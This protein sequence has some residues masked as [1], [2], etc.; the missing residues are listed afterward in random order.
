MNNNK[1]NITSKQIDDIKLEISKTLFL[2]A[3]TELTKQ[4]EIQ[5]AAKRCVLAAEEFAKAWDNITSNNALNP[6]GFVK[7]I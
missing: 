1:A 7:E 6:V 5:L 2:E 3:A 4:E